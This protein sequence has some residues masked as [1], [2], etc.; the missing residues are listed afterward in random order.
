MG[1]TVSRALKSAAFLLSPR[2]SPLPFSIQ[3][4]RGKEK[5]ME[6]EERE[7]QPLHSPF[8]LLFSRKAISF[9]RKECIAASLLCGVAAEEWY[10]M[11]RTKRRYMFH[12]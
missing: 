5:K 12:S 2:F 1:D 10:Y 4:W 7:E 3:I 6:Q 11:Y 9:T 8:F